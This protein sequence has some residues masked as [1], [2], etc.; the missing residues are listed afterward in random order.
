MLT[1]PDCRRPG[2]VTGRVLFPPGGVCAGAVPAGGR[3]GGGVRRPAG[4]PQ[5]AAGTRL[6]AHGRTAAGRARR[7]T[8]SLETG[9]PAR[10]RRRTCQ[11]AP[12]LVHTYSVMNSARRAC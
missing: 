12:V 9:A 8:S 1:D 10:T 3:S 4:L 7:R 6:A 11:G 5:P 2:E